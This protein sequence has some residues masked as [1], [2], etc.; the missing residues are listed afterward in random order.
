M[1]EN[2]PYLDLIFSMDHAAADILGISFNIFYPAFN[3]LT[4]DVLNLTDEQLDKDLLEDFKSKKQTQELPNNVT[5]LN[6]INNITDNKN[7]DNNIIN[8]FDEIYNE[9]NFGLLN[10]IN[11]HIEHFYNILN[12]IILRRFFQ[13]IY[14]LNITNKIFEY[15]FHQCTKY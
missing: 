15:N 2:L 7:I 4:K 5:V 9:Q 1:M 11:N 12:Y 14:I 10:I 8:I 3:W 13:H 6:N